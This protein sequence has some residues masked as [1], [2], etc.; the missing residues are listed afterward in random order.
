MDFRGGALPRGTSAAARAQIPL[1]IR[2]WSRSSANPCIF[3]VPVGIVAS[4]LSLLGPYAAATV[5][6]CILLACLGLTLWLLGVTDWRVY[7]VVAMWPSSIAALQTG[8]V[9]IIVALCIA[10]AVRLQGHRILPGVA[11]GAAIAVKLFPWPLIIWLAAKRRYAAAAVAASIS[12]LTILSALPFISLSSYAHLMKNLGDTFGPYSYNLVGLLSQLG[13]TN[14]NV[15]QACA[16]VVGAA[17]LVLAAHRR[18]LTL[19]IAACLTLSPIVWTHYLVVLAVPLASR[20]PRFALPWLIPLALI[21]CPG[22]GTGAV[23]ET[24]AGLAVIASVTVL[25]EWPPATAARSTRPAVV[26]AAP[27]VGDLSIGTDS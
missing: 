23:W 26:A 14:V 25:A 7:G 17:I 5:F 10:A 16:Y 20:W 1:R 19:S 2:T 11:I 12:V 9:S 6:S 27:T 15:A 22:G 3:P 4:P 21:L 8:N 18:S 24:L 13:V